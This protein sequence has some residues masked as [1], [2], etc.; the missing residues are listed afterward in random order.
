M[1][2]NRHKEWAKI[3]PSGAGKV[4]FS[5]GTRGRADNLLLELE[6]ASPSTTITIELESSQEWGKSPT[7]VRPT[8]K[9]RPKLWNSR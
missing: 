8:R 6:G 3:D 9:L 5:T 4:E 2:D 7:P 1:F